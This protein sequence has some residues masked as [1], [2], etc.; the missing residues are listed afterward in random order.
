MRHLAWLNAVPVP[1]EGSKRAA[2]QAS[3]LSRLE[4]MK[5]DKI[6][7]PMPPKPLPH[8][9]DRLVEMGISEAA[10][11]GVVPLGWPTI[12]AWCVRTGVDLSP[13][14]SRLIRRLSAAYVAEG[15][16]AESETAAPPWHAPV[17]ARECEAEV[18]G[19][20]MLLG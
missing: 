7:P 12:D 3:K 17:T 10:G 13:W 14:E 2:R 18:A 5:R 6:D 9:I 11:M 8:I 16:R 19:L 15:R 1:P 20:D 4:K